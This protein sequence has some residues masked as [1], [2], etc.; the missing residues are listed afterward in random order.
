MIY[1]AL[2]LFLVVVITS[3][4]IVDVRSGDS[5]LLRAAFTWLKEILKL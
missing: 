2:A 1:V 3:V 4:A 5:S